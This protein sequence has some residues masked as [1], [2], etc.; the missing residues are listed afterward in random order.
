MLPADN[1]RHTGLGRAKP[2][3]LRNFFRR[4]AVRRDEVQRGAHERGS[5]VLDGWLATLVVAALM[6][7]STPISAMASDAPPTSDSTFVSVPPPATSLPLAASAPASPETSE[8]VTAPPTDTPSATPPAIPPASETPVPTETTTTTTTAASAQT[9][10][11]ITVGPIVGA[12]SL[13]AQTLAA[14]SLAAQT[15]V[16]QRAEAVRASAQK[17]VSDRAL[18]QALV[19]ERAAAVQ[20]A[21]AR[22]HTAQVA[23]AAASSNVELTRA[24]QAIARGRT[25][26]VHRLAVDASH[27]ASVSSRGVAQVVRKLA[28]QQDGAAVADI[29]FG[30]HSLNHLLDQLGTLNR[31]QSATENIHSLQA[32]AEADRLRAAKLHQQ[33]AEARAAASLISVDASQAAFDAATRSF[34]AA[35]RSV[36]TAASEAATAAASLAALGVQPI[37]DTDVGQLSAQGWANPALGVITDTYGPRPIRPLPGVGSFHYGSDIGASCGTP[38]LAATSGIVLSVGSVGSYGNWILLDHGEGVQTGYAHLSS[39]PAVVE[40]G[41]RVTAG[42]QMGNVGSTGLSTGCHV[43]I[44]VRVAGVRVDPQPFFFNRGVNLGR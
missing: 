35:G 33:D 38:V 24:S 9:T 10:E 27:R 40:V 39:G 14:Q 17:I 15:V 42:Q 7:F 20:S 21:L 11:A 13:A 34:E 28:R 6:L 4:R 19:G 36:G 44:E 41:N 37:V 18:A 5:G 12:Q 43:H 1:H 22:F 30:G 29:F 16:A 8:P 3:P 23:L 32:R 31:L 2:T 26:L 25:T